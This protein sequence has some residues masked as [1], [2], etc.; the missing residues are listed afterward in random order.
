MDC[1]L[2]KLE[3]WHVIDN[4]TVDCMHDIF[5]GWV[6]L[7]LRC[8]VKKFIDDGLFT[9]VLLNARIRSFNYGVYDIKN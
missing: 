7:E 4:L 6:S 9:L 2:N 3:Y 1:C 5:E 8:V